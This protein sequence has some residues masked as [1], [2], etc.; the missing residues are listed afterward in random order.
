[1]NSAQRLVEAY[2]LADEAA[3]KLTVGNDPVSGYRLLHHAVVTSMSQYSS[4]DQAAEVLESRAA[5]LRHSE[6]PN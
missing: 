2:R 1:M 4:P 5:S 6:Q 3:A